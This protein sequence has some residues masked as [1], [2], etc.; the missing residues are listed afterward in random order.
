M[1]TMNMIQA[2]NDAH[3]VMMARDEDVVVFGEDVGYFGGVFRV[4][5]GL[6]KQFGKTRVFDTPIS[7][8]GIVAT[9]VGMAAYGLQA[10]RRDPVRRLHLPGLRPDRQRSRADAL[11]PGGR[12]ADADGH[13][14]AL[15]R[16][17][18]RRPDAQP[19]A[20][21]ALHPCRRPEGR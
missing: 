6:Q 3:K 21:I 13:P 4:T 20:R 2:L 17:H 14:H 19:V 18:L 10:G 16:R 1:P 7:E 15:R 9:A 5:E 11:P 8:G 12:V